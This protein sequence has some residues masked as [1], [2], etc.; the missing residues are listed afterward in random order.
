MKNIVDFLKVFK[1]IGGAID[2]G[3][4]DEV[5][6]PAIDKIDE[7]MKKLTRKNTKITF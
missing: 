6:M 1:N 5:A 4:I 3:L 2:S 7:L